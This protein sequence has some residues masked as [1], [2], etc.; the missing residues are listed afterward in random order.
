MGRAAGEEATMSTRE[1]SPVRA[2]SDAAVI[3][4]PFEE[5]PVAQAA[6]D[7]PDGV[8]VA[9][10]AAY[11][12]LTGREDPIGQ[13]FR[14]VPPGLGAQQLA[15]L[16]DRVYS[17]GQE[18][19][20]REW[21]VRYRR[22]TDGRV[23]EGYFDFNGTPRRGPDGTV[24][25]VIVSIA[26]V[27][28]RVRARQ[29]ARD[30]V[31]E[32]ERRRTAAREVAA[33]LQEA[34]LPA[35][36]PVLPRARIAAR[37]LVAPDDQ[38]PG[39]DW[40]DA[41]P[42]PCG[43]VA[44]VVG[45][46]A[47]HGAAAAAAMA[48]LRAVLRHELAAQPDLA[49][50]LARVDAF[51]AADPALRAA[52]VCAAV[53]EPVT[54]ALRY[55]DFGH[56][57]PLIVAPNGTTRYLPATGTGPLGTGSAVFP[58]TAVLRIEETVLLY[59]DG[60]VERPGRALGHGL[61]ELAA[62]AADAVTGRT[63]PVSPGSTPAERVCELTVTALAGSGRG[64]DVTTLAAQR[65]PAPPS[66]DVEAAVDRGAVTTLRRELDDWLAGIGVATADRQIAELAVT[67][68][69]S[70]AAEHAYAP[71]RPGPVRLEAELGAD[72]YLLARVSDRGRW[73]VPDPGVQDDRGQGLMLAGQLAGELTVSHPPQEAGAPPGRRG[74]IVT[75]R[76][77]LRRAPVLA[78]GPAVSAGMIAAAAADA[79][80]FT[81]EQVAAG[82][83][84]HVRVCGP[85]DIG[86]ADRLASR[87]LETCRGG[88][89]P[90]TADLTGV[91]ILATAGVRALYDVRDRLAA[92]RQALTLTA[93]PGSPAAAVLDLVG[94][95][96]PG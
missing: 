2:A 32:T 62:L 92:H 1:D 74:T 28:A 11:R 29:Q 83:V 91:T 9:A 58:G 7:G 64:D 68:A 70:N 56:P 5:S 61:A 25:G 78:A 86:T 26:D 82:P 21:R 19:A 59:S 17:T 63:L 84:P 35:S 73:R 15:E 69:V 46:V 10:N 66:L 48:Q 50:T 33:A 39:G 51:A 8:C 57:P 80:P 81:V 44:L 72:G 13:P 34:L 93:A 27:T 75:L 79:V 12:T 43:S 76:H 38:A 4:R 85:A 55:C 60:L 89:L 88:V 65:L 54:G 22:D 20:V 53:L 24:S 31:A 30:T 40:F 95:S 67:E 45:D 16:Y 14:A 41:L 42:L 6:M 3:R 52:T 77:R 94:L 47:G 87:L 23:G 96:L 37:Y 18:D 71:G 90:L 36:L 49:V